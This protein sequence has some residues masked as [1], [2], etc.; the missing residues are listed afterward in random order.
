VEGTLSDVA[1]KSKW[2]SSRRFDPKSPGNSEEAENTIAKT[3]G[4][5]KTDNMV[6]SEPSP[7]SQPAR[8]WK[9]NEP[10][11]TNNFDDPEGPGYSEA[12]PINEEMEE[13][14][15]TEEI[16]KQENKVKRWK[17]SRQGLWTVETTETKE[18]VTIVHKTE[19]RGT[20]GGKKTQGREKTTEDEKR[21]EKRARTRAERENQWRGLQQTP[22]DKTPREMQ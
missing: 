19:E 4:N 15:P 21:G 2:D 8:K 14:E 18:E 12:S 7:P 20:T 6:E 3:R 10:Y 11:I 5:Q 13:N 22:L 9:N 16:A 1:E 17:N